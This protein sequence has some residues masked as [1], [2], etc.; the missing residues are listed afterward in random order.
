MCTKNH[1]HMR[2]GSWD[3][4]WERNNFLSLWA[5]L[6][7]FPLQSTWKIKI[8]KKWKKKSLQ[9][10]SFYTWAPQRTIIWCMFPEIWRVTDRTFC[11]FGL[12][13]FFCLTTQKIKIL[14]E[15]KHLEI[16]SFY[17]CVPQMKIIW[18]MAPK[19]WSVTDRIFSHFGP[20]F[21]PF[22]PLTV[23]K[24]KTL[25]KWKKK[26][27]KHTHTHTRGDIITLHKC[28]KNH[29]HMLYCS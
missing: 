8:L 16:L 18:C 25:K 2:Y 10:S 5:I 24:I 21:S 29:D 14:N 26:K 12:F 6:C 28:T 27:K 4:E 20:F 19:I 15:K 1:N 11:L 3:K 13:L 22:T 7:P 17:T 23:Q 9:I